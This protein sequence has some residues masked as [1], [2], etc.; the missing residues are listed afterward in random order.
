MRRPTVHARLPQRRAAVT[1][2][3]RIDMGTAHYFDQTCLR[4]NGEECTMCVDHCPVGTRPW[5]FRTA[6]STSTKTAAPA[7]ASVKTI[8]RPIRRASSSF[9][10]LRGTG[11]STRRNA[12]C[13]PEMRPHWFRRLR[14]TPESDSVKNAHSPRNRFS[15]TS[16]ISSTGARKIVHASNCATAC[17]R[18]ISI[19]P[20][21]CAPAA[22]ACWSSFVWIGL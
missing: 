5:K 19:P 18:N 3:P 10:K 7:A 20:I 4:F 15:T 13:D 1:P 17:R 9:R 14:R 21:V 16:R 11:R 6:G 2:L 12:K 8:A 22:S